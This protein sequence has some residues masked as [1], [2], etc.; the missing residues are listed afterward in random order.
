M[1]K[2][3]F[4]E[5]MKRKTN[6]ELTETIRLAIKNEGWNRIAQI[7]ASSTKN[8]AS[9]N[10]LK[11]DKESKVGDTIIV[12]GKVLSNGNLSKKIKICALAISEQAKE[13]LKSSKTEFCP[14]IEEIKKNPKAEG[15][16]LLR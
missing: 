1:S 6:N 14:I 9:I 5:R 11:I 8:Q 2:T 10:L 15:I 7:L 13:K 4:K 3:K 12:P 16:K